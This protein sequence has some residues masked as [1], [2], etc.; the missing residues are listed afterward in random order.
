MGGPGGIPDDGEPVSTAV[1]DGPV[2]VGTGM[3]GVSGAVGKICTLDSRMKSR[4]FPSAC[5]IIYYIHLMA[6]YVIVGSGLQDILYNYY[7]A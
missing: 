3:E 5:G 7:N 2:D 1:L 6:G 4:A